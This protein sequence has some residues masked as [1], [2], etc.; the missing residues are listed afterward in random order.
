MMRR[1]KKNRQTPAT[2]AVM[3]DWASES[4]SRQ[5]NQTLQLFHAQQS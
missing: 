1:Q 4:L 3:I 2:S 5:P